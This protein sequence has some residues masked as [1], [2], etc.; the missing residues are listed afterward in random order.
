MDIKIRKLKSNY[1]NVLEGFIKTKN[2]S[3]HKGI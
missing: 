1:K 2:S 3:E